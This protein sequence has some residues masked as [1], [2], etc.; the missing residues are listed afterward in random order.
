MTRY[1]LNEDS[2]WGS[3]VNAVKTKAADMVG[4]DKNQALGR[5]M[6]ATYKKYCD[7]N[8]LNPYAT[9]SFHGFA[10]EIF[11]GSDRFIST[12]V[13]HFERQIA[14]PSGDA[15]DDQDTVDT[16]EDT[17]VEQDENT[18]DEPEPEEQKPQRKS[19]SDRQ[20]E[21]IAENNAQWDKY[22]SKMLHA[23]NKLRP[24]D[25]FPKNARTNRSNDGLV[26][27]VTKKNKERIKQ[28]VKTQ[29][30]IFNELVQ[31]HAD[32]MLV[33]CEDAHSR[34]ILNSLSLDELKKSLETAKQIIGCNVDEK[35]HRLFIAKVV[36]PNIEFTGMAT[37]RHINNE[38]LTDKRANSTN[39]SIST[40]AET[41]IL[42]E[43]D[44]K[45]LESFFIELARQSLISGVAKSSAKN[46]LRQEPVMT[47]DEQAYIPD[48]GSVATS[49]SK[50]SFTRRELGIINKLKDQKT[51]LDKLV[52]VRGAGRFGVDENDA[53]ELAKKLLRNSINKINEF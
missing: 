12:W 4:L 45:R 48:R 14:S 25:P 46:S 34:S 17:D 8:G 39:E 52:T 27:I 38:P 30:G 42:L 50:V 43:N 26:I 11:E 41:T 3:F 40:S 47:G 6:L 21:Q 5:K 28:L 37:H 44:A 22:L 20:A 29:N 13:N 18:D 1:I 16:D 35:S 15:D 32:G 53:A 23:K 49:V 24:Y 33:T 7:K 10:A 31:L 36:N 2:F 9:D 51:S 19:L